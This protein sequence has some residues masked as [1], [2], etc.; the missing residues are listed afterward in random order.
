MCWKIDTSKIDFIKK[1]GPLKKKGILEYEKGKG[2]R[3]CSDVVSARRSK[4]GL[5]NGEEES[6]IKKHLEKLLFKNNPY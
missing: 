2:L 6:N 5:I 4:Y 3:T 1:G